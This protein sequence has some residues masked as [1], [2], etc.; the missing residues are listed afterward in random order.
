V[1][2]AQA[3]L[4]YASFGLIFT[5]LSVIVTPVMTDLNLSFSQMGFI[6]GS[7]QLVYT[8]AAIP[9]G[10]LT[11]RI[12]PY[13]SLL[14]ATT[15]ISLSAVLRSFAVNFETLTV[16]VAFFGIG[17]S[18]ISVGL[19][20]LASM[21]FVGRERGTATG[22]YTSVSAIGSIAALSLTNGAVIPLVGSWR[23]AYLTYGFIGF[24]TATVWLFMGR[25]SPSSSESKITTSVKRESMGG[26]KEAFKCKNVWLIVII[27]ISSFLTSHG[28]SN[29]LPKILQLKGMTPE[30][31]GLAVS[32]LTVVG[33]FAC[34]LIP[35][36]P[37]LMGSKKLAISVVLLVQGIAIILLGI[38]D[39]PMLWLA[40]ALD[41]ISRGVNPLLVVILMD[42]PEVGPKRMGVIGGL[43]FAIGEIGGFGGPFLMGLLKDITGTFL[44]GIA[45][46]AVVC[47]ASIVLAVFLKV[48]T[49][50]KRT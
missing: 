48:E 26:V 9:L 38:T 12:G 14:L 28:L 49:Q 24:L 32:V 44:T 29:W 46:L 8:C 23:N 25:R 3:G 35:R 41:G 36:L 16:F 7:W 11:D 50:P 34:L 45:V 18:L 10:F 47:E 17:G 20:K 42:L 5:T 40:L 39:G 37:Y 21:W 15:L 13:K 30:V 31:A 6:L 1:I 43:F 33:I 19:P 22:V 27:G 2:L 4:I